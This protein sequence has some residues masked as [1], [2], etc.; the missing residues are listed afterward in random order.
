MSFQ[1]FPAS[2]PYFDALHDQALLDNDIKS[3]SD[4]IVH[5]LKVPQGSM[6]ESESAA[7]ASS[8]FM[9]ALTGI[10]N[11]QLTTNG[12]VAHLSTLD[13]C[14]DLYNELRKSASLEVIIPLLDKAWRQDSVTTLHII[15]HARSI[16][17]GKSENDIFYVAFGWLLKNHPQTALRNLQ[18]LVAGCIPLKKNNKRKREAKEEGWELMDEDGEDDNALF[19]THGYWKDL[20]NLCTLYVEGELFTGPENP[21]STFKALNRKQPERKEK[22][23]TSFQKWT[24]RKTN[25][26]QFYESIRDLPEQEQ[27][28]KRAE[29]AAQIQERLDQEKEA[30]K[31]EKRALRGTRQ[32]RISKLLQEDKLYRSLHFTVA[33][34][35]ADRL[36]KDLQQ[37]KDNKKAK[38]NDGSKCDKYADAKGLSL[39]SKWAP[40]LRRA[41]DK[42]TLL[43]TSIAEALYPPS[44]HQEKEE[45][46]EHYLNKVR[47]LYRKEYLSP[48]RGALVVTESLMSS[49]QWKNIDFSHVSSK[50]M[51]RNSAN[52]Y[53]HAEK[54]F[55]QYMETVIKGKRTISGATLQP[56]EL[57]ELVWKIINPGLF[58]IPVAGNDQKVKQAL[59]DLEANR[60]N[61][62]WKTLV[63]SIRNSAVDNEKSSVGEAIAVCD[64]SGS[65]MD[66]YGSPVTPMHASIGLSILLAELAKPPFTNAMISFTE[67]AQAINL[68]PEDTFV[69]KVRKVRRAPWGGS[70][71]LLSVFEDVIL[72]I[73]KKN[74]LKQK[75]MVKRLF[76]FTDMEFDCNGSFANRWETT[77]DTIKKLFAEAGY[78]VPEIVWWNLSGQRY[79]YMRPESSIPVTKDV[80]GC[81]LLSGYSAAL[82]KT[83]IE[84]EEAEEEEE[85]D[86]DE[87]TQDGEEKPK[88]KKREK[89]TPLGIMMKAVYHETFKDLAVYD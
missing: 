28:Q 31:N 23:K 70:T 54:E 42:Y 16:H 40:T 69:E 44:A 22:A 88:P 48:L 34:L 2:L 78:E 12:A 50:C 74:N 10:G 79:S 65:M 76:V 9:D 20:A 30:Q 43:A 32:E 24:E 81:A 26:K 80:E 61:A 53:K 14:L 85:Q 27:A 47:E 1:T 68:D 63:E 67:V 59:M 60:A 72:P 21:D 41:H 46:R 49:N 6:D 33:R 89:I 29:R 56:H 13:A 8:P 71:N 17:Q 57:V 3:L 86:Q 4:G 87:N 66:A 11:L 73:A 35:F 18:L 45:T 36:S 82:M 55:L 84:G 52:F 37:L 39:A 62:Q 83:F 15:W 58:E 64:V 75:D 25:S 51:H 19:A 38:K 7:A 77:Y 5:E